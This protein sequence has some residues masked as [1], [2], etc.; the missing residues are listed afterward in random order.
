[1]LV[2]QY[3]INDDTLAILPAREIEYQSNILDDYCGAKAPVL[4]T[5][6]PPFANDSSTS[7]EGAPLCNVQPTI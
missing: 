5:L 4:R 3:L 1:M 7:A 2:N 6:T